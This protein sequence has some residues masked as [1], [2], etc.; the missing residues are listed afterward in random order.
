MPDNTLFRGHLDGSHPP[1]CDCGCQDHEGGGHDH[2]RFF[3]GVDAPANATTPYA[4][5]VGDTFVGT[6]S[7][8]GEA[9]FVRVQLVAGETYVFELSGQG[10]GDGTLEDP[11]LYLLDSSGVSIVAQD[12]DDGPGRDSTITFTATTSGTYYL[13]ADAYIPT[14]GP[15]YTGTYELS[16][17]TTTPPPPPEVG[18]LD[19]LAAFLTDGYWGA[20]GGRAWDTSTSNQITV[21]I[22]ALTAEGQQ[23]A[24]WAFEAWEMVANIEFVEVFG[25]ADMTFDDNQS[26]A[27]AST[28]AQNGVSQSST[29]NVSTAWLAQYGTSIDSYSFST[30]VH[31]IGHALG[32]GHQGAY[33]GSATYGTDET[34]VNDSYLVSVMSYFSQT[35]NTS[36]QGSYGE[37]ITAMMADLVAIQN[38]YGAPDASTS[39]TAGDTTWGANSNLGNYLETYWDIALTSATNTAVDNGSSTVFTIYDVSGTDTVDISFS[40]V[41]NRADLNEMAYS[42]IDGGV[43]NV[44]IGRG[45]TIENAIG[46]S[47]DDEITGNRAGNEIHGGGGNDTILGGV[48]FDTLY[49][50]A[51]NDF[52][53]GGSFADQLYGG[54]GNDTLLGG[55]GFD[56]LYGEDGNDLLLGGASADRLFGGDG[57][58]TLRAGTNFGSSVDGLVG[59]AGNDRLYGEGGFDTLSGGTGNDYL[60]GGA[61]ADNLFGETGADILLGGAGFDRLFGGV[62]NDN[63]DGGEGTDSLYGGAGFDILNGGTGNDLLVGNFNADTF[64]FDNGHGQDIIRDFDALSA[65]ERIDFSNLSSMNNFGQVQGAMSTVNGGADVLIDTGGGNSILLEGVSIGDLDASDFIF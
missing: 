14:T 19:E 2:A 43:N 57:D 33:N 44:A 49:G 20:R 1:D 21:N 25:T 4:I 9:D 63:L 54:T 10:S 6:L 23:L 46:G 32:L 3:E 7:S 58:D 17:D 35:Q 51:G 42:D 40:S 34:F 50:D 26:G 22:T 13:V 29:I 64:V 47:G 56:N 52:L 16:M 53:D 65:A 30:Y 8:A 38:L 39:V 18:T 61:Q 48:G 60:N 55:D 41:A 5:G 27:F 37:P 36:V 24:R 12:D 62:G 59:G 15:L 31:E 28:V 11:Y 45:V